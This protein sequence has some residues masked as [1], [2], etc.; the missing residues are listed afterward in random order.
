MSF[1]DLE[2][3][4]EPS[5]G[6]LYAAFPTSPT[7]LGWRVDHP[8][9]TL[10]TLEELAAGSYEPADL[11]PEEILMS[12][13][14]AP[15][16]SD[17]MLR[18]SCALLLLNAQTLKGKREVYSEQI[19]SMGISVAVFLETRSRKAMQTPCGCFFRFESAAEAGEGGCALYFRTTGA[20]KL[21]F[22]PK[23]HAGPQVLAVTAPIAG[24]P[25]LNSVWPCPAFW[26]ISG[27]YPSLVDGP[28]CPALP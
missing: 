9:G 8:D 7:R 13:R 21:C 3:G 11:V 27:R 17:T 10:P 12:I 23:A 19:R 16:T 28:L 6:T 22:E 4:A 24:V 25:H 18:I 20:N 14:P 15:S 1:L 26:Q 5:R 2:L